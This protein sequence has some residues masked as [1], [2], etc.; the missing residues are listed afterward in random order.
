VGHIVSGRF[1]YRLGGSVLEAVKPHALGP[2]H[3]NLANWRTAKAGIERIVVDVLR[4]YG[5]L[6]PAPKAH[7]H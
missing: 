1:W 2:G 3:G 6:E 5:A 4:K 7:R